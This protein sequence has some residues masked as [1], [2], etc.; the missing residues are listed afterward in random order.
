[1]HSNCTSKVTYSQFMNDESQFGESVGITLTSFSPKALMDISK[2]EVS[3]SVNICAHHINTHTHTL[4][5][6]FG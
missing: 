5:H 3:Q 2:Q 4:T 1:M 6:S